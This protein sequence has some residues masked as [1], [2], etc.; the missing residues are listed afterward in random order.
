MRALKLCPVH[1]E[2]RYRDRRAVNKL[3][4]RPRSVQDGKPV[5]TCAHARGL[6]ALTRSLDRNTRCMCAVVRATGLRSW[7]CLLSCAHRL[8][9]ADARNLTG[10]DAPAPHGSAVRARPFVARRHRPWR[11]SLRARTRPFHTV[12]RAFQSDRRSVPVVSAEHEKRCT[13]TDVVFGAL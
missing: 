6:C 3:T 12:S 8:R 2:H 10:L 7:R 5:T 1:F 11:D 9:V 13:A 4:V